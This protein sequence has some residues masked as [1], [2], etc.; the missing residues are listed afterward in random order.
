LTEDN[1]KNLDGKIQKES[2]LRDKKE[3]IIDDHRSQKSGD[4]GRARSYQRP[5]TT[6]AKRQVNAGVG[7][8]N[9]DTRS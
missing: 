7:D 4:G 8:N 9:Q 6:G 5:G 1:L 3:A 2:E